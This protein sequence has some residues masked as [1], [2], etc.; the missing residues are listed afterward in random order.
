[1]PTNCHPLTPGVNNGVVVHLQ[2]K[3]CGP[4]CR[5]DSRQVDAIF[6]PLEVVGPTI[7]AWM[8][9]CGQVAGQ[10]VLVMRP[11]VFE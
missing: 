4:A 2:G 8:E 7:P 11:F 10:W 5:C 6:V 9:D 3:Q 1:M